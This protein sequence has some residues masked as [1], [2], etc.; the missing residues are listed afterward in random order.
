MANE[1]SI[2]RL[3]WDVI[4][5][6]ESLEAVHQQYREFLE[7]M[8]PGVTRL[9]E[10]QARFEELQQQMSEA[11]GRFLDADQAYSQALSFDPQQ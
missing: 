4:E 8:R 3:R 5:G 2:E 9:S 11:R 10:R 6:L 7:A 1:V